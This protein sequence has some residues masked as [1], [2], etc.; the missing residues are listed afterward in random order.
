MSVKRLYP[1]EAN[2]EYPTVSPERTAHFRIDAGAQ[3][4]G[5][6]TTL[7][8]PAGSAVTGWRAKV[9]EAVTSGGSATVQL[10]FSGTTMLS[11][12]IA[13]ATLVAGYEFG[14]D[15]TADAAFYVMTAADT[16][17]SIVGTATLTAGKFDVTVWYH[18]PQEGE[19]DSTFPEWVTA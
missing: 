4:A 8:L 16:F 17:D 6:A 3:A 7:Q 18:P 14:P 5:T 9:T 2:N 15:H 12:A 11:A 10:G 13:K 1:Y 19:M